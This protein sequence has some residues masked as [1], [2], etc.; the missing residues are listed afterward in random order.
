MQFAYVEIQLT[1]TWFSADCSL[2]RACRHTR[3]PVAFDMWPDVFQFQRHQFC[4]LARLNS[5]SFLHWCH[6]KQQL[7]TWRTNRSDSVQRLFQTLIERAV[8]NTPNRQNRYE[9]QRVGILDRAA[10]K[11][12]HRNLEFHCCKYDRAKQ[13]EKQIN[14]L[15]KFLTIQWNQCKVNHSI[16][17]HNKQILVSQ[18]WW[19]FQ[20]T[21]IHLYHVGKLKKI[22]DYEDAK[23]ISSMN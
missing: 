23:Y 20:D 19:N 7:S 10:P 9:F 17:M 6:S 5:K 11:R 22:D 15:A 1:L 8:I 4:G 2:R 14:K 21:F 3:V 16:F 18:I 12:R 13:R